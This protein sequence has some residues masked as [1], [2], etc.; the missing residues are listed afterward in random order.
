[1][2]KRAEKALLKEN[3]LFNDKIKELKGMSNITDKDALK[4]L[5]E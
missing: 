3:Q 5:L 4:K 1:M 2:K